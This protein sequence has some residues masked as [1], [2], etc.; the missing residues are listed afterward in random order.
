[1]SLDTLS[2]DSWLRPT[3]ETPLQ[4]MLQPHSEPA[5]LIAN[6]S[7]WM[8]GTFTVVFLVVMLL[9]GVA[10]WRGMRARTSLSERAS[11]NLVLLGGVVVP[12]FIL[13]ALV[14]ASILVGQA[15]SGEQGDADLTAEVI[16]HRWWWEIRYRDRDDNLLAVAANELHLPAGETVRLVLKASDVIHSFWAPNLDGKTDMIPGMTNERWLRIDRPGVYRGQC[17]EFCG[18]QHALMAVRIEVQAQPAFRDWL[19]RQGEPAVAAALAMDDARQIFRER[20]CADCHTI[21]GTRAGGQSGPDL[22]HLASRQTLAAAT[23]PNNRGHLG[24]W[25][26]DPQSNKPGVLMPATRLQPAELRALLDYLQALE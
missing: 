8:I 26:T 1:M 22:T 2:R 4:S 9:A 16:G 3:S 24:G 17:A 12:S 6:L 19:Q 5:A 20:G 15:S 11:R 13:L 21:R 18:D 7:W 10:L 23:L 25:I 14:I